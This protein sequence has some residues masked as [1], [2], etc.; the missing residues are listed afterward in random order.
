MRKF[1]L[2]I[3]CSCVLIG[4]EKEFF[5]IE[6][7][8][9]KSYR[10]VS[11]KKTEWDYDNSFIPFEMNGKLFAIDREKTSFS[12]SYY[13]HVFDNTNQ[14]WIY[15]TNFDWSEDLISSVVG[16]NDKI[17]IVSGSKFGV[18]SFDG[19]EMK[20]GS[21][22]QYWSNSE[23]DFIY[24]IA[25]SSS[26][27]VFDESGFAHYGNVSSSY[28][29]SPNKKYIG[30]IFKDYVD[31]EGVNYAVSENGLYV[32]GSGITSWSKILS[33]KENKIFLG[34]FNYKGSYAIAEYNDTSQYVNILAYENGG[35]IATDT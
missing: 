3:F 17:I 35:D 8:E 21:T 30:A 28:F 13:L 16:L 31:I 14:K 23:R 26:Y 34:V 27:V 5:V 32:S 24:A 29:S 20:E 2:I 12:Y 15:V 19:N 1:F 10:D 9:Q 22:E 25:D 6:E 33:P 11:T 18:F 4:C 7:K